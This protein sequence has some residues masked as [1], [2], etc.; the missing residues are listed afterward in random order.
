MIFNQ[1]R[2]FNPTGLHHFEKRIADVDA[3]SRIDLS[4]DALSDPIEGSEPFEL[5]NYETSKEMASDILKSLAKADPFALLENIGLW[6]WLT[7]LLRHQLFKH[8]PDG[9]LRIGEYHRWFPSAANDWQKGQRH[10]V[11]MPVFLLAALNE[12]ADHLLCSPPNTLPEIREQMTGQYDMMTPAFQKLARALYYDETIG[13]LK[14][15]AGGKGA[16]SPRRLRTLRRQLGVTWQVEDLPL[17]KMLE[18]LPAE[19]DRFLMTNVSQL[20]IRM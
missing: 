9:S 4:D 19:F 5:K 6:A 10:L 20:D 13:K 17:E 15:G 2:S 18:K 1:L 7:F 3:D 16:G 14:R 11:R 8:N 12:D